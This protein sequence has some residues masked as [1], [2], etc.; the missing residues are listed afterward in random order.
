MITLIKYICLFF[1]EQIKDAFIEI[2]RINETA[3][4]TDG[5]TQADIE[6]M[7]TKANIHG[8]IVILSTV[9]TT[10][11]VIYL[12]VYGFYDEIVVE[13]DNKET[14]ARKL[15]KNAIVLIALSVIIDLI[16]RVI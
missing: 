9:I 15:R 1:Y 5:V 13:I 2:V 4:V 3:Q 14:T 6:A 8:V 10:I 11:T 7:L 12:F 16:S